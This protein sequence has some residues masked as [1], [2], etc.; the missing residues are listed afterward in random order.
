MNI[1]I[2]CPSLV[3]INE[4]KKSSLGGVE[5]LVLTLANELSKKNYNIT[6]SSIYK[7]K[8]R[9][10]NI[11]YVPIKEI[12]RN[13][14]NYDFSSIISANDATI[15]DSF[16]ENKNKIFWLHNNLQIEK[17]IRKKQFYSIIKNN[18]KAVFVSKY[19]N[20]LTSYLYLFKKRFVIHNFLLPNFNQ[21]KVKY[22]RKPIFVWSVQRDKG[23]N[24]TINMWV[25]YIYKDYKNAK[26]YIY[27][28]NKLPKNLNKKYLSSK[29]IF[30]KGRVPKNNL[31]KIYSESM[32]MICLGYDETFCL[33]ALE[34]NSCGLPVITL[35]KSALKYY[36]INKYNG[37]VVK[38]IPEIGT[39][40]KFL[41]NVKSRKSIIQN[42]IAISKKFSLN[43]IIHSWLKLLK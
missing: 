2:N 15:F 36:V 40:V 5:S 4:K 1:L 12:K 7:K 22:N 32:G 31:K 33:N 10:N 17:S 35:G 25:N 43:I 38:N 42:S 41:L 9:K 26:F 20:K 24:E 16:K 6:I 13:P 27:G 3:D 34:A 30:F 39:K 28:I 19:L 37:Y 29:N 8:I 23:L 18:P 11:L 21:T 14:K